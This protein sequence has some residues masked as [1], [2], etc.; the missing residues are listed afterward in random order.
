[1]LSHTHYTL[2]LSVGFSS[3]LWRHR[4][5]VHY[6]LHVSSWRICRQ[7]SCLLWVLPPSELVMC[8]ASSPHCRGLLL[9]VP[10]SK[11]LLTHASY[12]ALL[13]TLHMCAWSLSSPAP[14]SQCTCQPVGECD[15]WRQL[16]F[17]I[18]QLIA[19][20]PH[21]HIKPKVQLTLVELTT[22]YSSGKASCLVS[23]V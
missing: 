3:V 15:F 4:K 18:M 12:S 23:E 9:H 5:S 21:V 13:F 7:L 8:I 20:E 22:L 16:L 17:S 14:S 19:K 11:L 6:L 2:F 10:F 1:M